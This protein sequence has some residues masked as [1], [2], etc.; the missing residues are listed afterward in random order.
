MC[1]T[2][3]RQ[4]DFGLNFVALVT[5]WVGDEVPEEDVKGG[6]NK[7]GHEGFV[8]THTQTDDVAEH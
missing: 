7:M 3:C 4:N 5:G 6:R 8:N 1:I 2:N